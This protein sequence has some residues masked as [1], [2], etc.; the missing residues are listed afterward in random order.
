MVKDASFLSFM[1]RISHGRVQSDL[2]R[3]F[4]RLLAQ[5]RLHNE[6]RRENFTI[7]VEPNQK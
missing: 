6:W 1:E 2:R 3:E 4:A 5:Y 7:T